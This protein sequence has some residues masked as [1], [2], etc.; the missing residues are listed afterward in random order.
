MTKKEFLNELERKLKGLPK[1][2]IEDRLSFYSEM[3]D[4]Y[5]EDGLTIEEAINKIGSSDEIVSKIVNE[6]SLTKIVK[7]KVK[8]KRKLETW[9]IVLIVISFP[10]WLPLLILFL[11][12]VLVGFILLWSMVIVLWSVFGSLVGATASGLI[13]TLVL[14]FSDKLVISLGALGISLLSAGGAIFLFLA[15]VWATKYTFEL[16]KK[17][18]LKI[19][20]MINGGGR[21]K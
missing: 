12:F 8:P 6:T 13:N 21:E 19:K 14:L 7:E 18:I 15:S 1:Q 10:I 3:I 4:D 9:E 2:D 5:I 17:V 16:T 20:L 11:T